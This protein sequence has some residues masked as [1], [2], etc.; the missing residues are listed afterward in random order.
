MHK[1]YIKTNF[2]LRYPFRNQNTSPCA[3]E[4]LFGL[5]IGFLKTT[6]L[7]V[8]YLFSFPL[9]LNDIG[10]TAYNTHLH[11]VMQAVVVQ[12]GAT[13][14]KPDT[15]FFKSAQFCQYR[16]TFHGQLHAFGVKGNRHGQRSVFQDQL[17]VFLQQL[18]LQFRVAVPHTISVE[19]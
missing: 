12:A 17:Q 19:L 11:A 3:E 1:Y 16:R 6:I 10:H 9:S 7:E 13:D 8:D 18:K 2:G 5:K 14:Y 4:V 15:L